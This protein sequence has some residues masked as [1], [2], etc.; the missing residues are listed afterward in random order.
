MSDTE[1]TEQLQGKTMMFERIVNMQA[2]MHELES[3]YLLF[4]LLEKD[5]DNIKARII[6]LKAEFADLRCFEFK[7]EGRAI[8][9]YDE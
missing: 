9:F 2:F 5:V 3:Y 4:S 6:K 7:H 1:K 8:T